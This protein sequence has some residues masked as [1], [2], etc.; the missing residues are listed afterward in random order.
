MD[1]NHKLLGFN[2]NPAYN[3]PYGTDSVEN[4]NIAAATTSRLGSYWPAIVYQDSKGVLQEVR[5]YLG[6]AGPEGPS[7]SWL[8][9]SLSVTGMQGT[10]LGVVPL[11]TDFNI[12][13]FTWGGYGLFYQRNDGTLIAYNPDGDTANVTWTRSWPT[14]MSKGF[15]SV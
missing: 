14:G 11:A 13:G 8:T 4:V 7:A 1:G 6:G 10:Y 9:R 3:P 2:Y 5:N 12:T 15:S